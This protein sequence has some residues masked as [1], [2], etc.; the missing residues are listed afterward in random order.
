M[1]NLTIVTRTG[2]EKSITG[3][4]GNSLMETIR[5]NG[6]DELL[7]LCGGC[8]SC[9]TCHVYVDEAFVAK[10]PTMSADENDLLDSSDNR[11]ARSRL[12]CQVPLTAALDG[13][14]VQIAPED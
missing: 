14:R 7:S 1:V 12:S 9:S 4:E 2:E 8:C 3:T 5:D 6:F 10:L 13:M 11:E